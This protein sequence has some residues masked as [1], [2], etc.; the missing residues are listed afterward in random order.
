MIGER[1]TERWS[2]II[3]LIG[4]ASGV[5]AGFCPS[6][7]TVASPFFHEQEARDGNVKRIRAG[8]V[9]ATAIVLATG[10]A[11]GRSMKDPALFWSSAAIAGIF[12]AGYE[13]QIANPSTESGESGRET[14]PYPW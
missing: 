12:V 8:E 13:Y 7:F 9:A 5:F 3:L 6:W 1:S 14:F 11:L 4:E 10:Y 2:L